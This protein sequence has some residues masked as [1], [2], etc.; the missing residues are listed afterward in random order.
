MIKKHNCILHLI[1]ILTLFSLSS[2]SYS[3]LKGLS[4]FDMESLMK[5]DLL[6]NQDADKLQKLESM[7]TGNKINPDF[8]YVGP[9]DILAYQIL[10][11]SANSQYVI[12]SPENSILLPRFGEISLKD[13]TLT[14]TKK[15]ILD[16]IS[17]RNPNTVS[18]VVLFKPRTVIA[19][20]SGNVI[21]EG[22]MT[23]PASYNISTVYKLSNKISSTTRSSLTESFAYLIFTDKKHELA[24]LNAGT[25]SPNYYQYCSRNIFVKHDDGT[26]QNADILKAYTIN[27][28]SYDQYIREGDEIIVPFE[29]DEYPRISISGA[30]LNPSTLPY[31]KGDKASFLLKIA[32]GFNEDAD[33][34]N[35]F[36]YVPGSMEKEK[37]IVDYSM[38]LQSPD[39]DLTPGSMIL[40]GSKQSEQSSDVGM[41]AISGNVKN[42]GV[43]PI[44]ND[45]TKLKDAI[46]LAG[47]F[48]EKAYL[49][50]AK[51]YRR[52]NLSYSTNTRRDFEKK[53][54]YSDLTLQDTTRFNIDQNQKLPIVSCDLNALYNGNSS[55]DNIVLKDGDLIVI[56]SNPGSVF[57]YGQINK[58][59]YIMFENEK[60]MEW[61]I[62]RAGGIAE[63]G[64]SD[65]ARII[66]GKNHTWVE[67]DDDVMVYAGDEIYIPRAEDTPPGIEMQTWAMVVS[68]LG[69]TAAVINALIWIIH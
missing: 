31:K 3:Q 9:G 36:I 25:G 16:M 15:L 41:V 51:I 50:L 28:P 54:Q 63:G 32:G 11:A 5:E 22:T 13:R 30:V 4:Q 56:P 26:S 52:S 64:K 60:N 2:N 21:S 7:P 43:Y 18:S 35:I 20:I 23:L 12:V 33:L 38:N 34:D 8:Y 39:I 69:A 10:S 29:P 6:M 66:R 42:P 24:K 59:G 45:K 48:N 37:L 47:G 44:A 57:I 1:L 67:G 46:E 65:R 62:Q 40:V 68:A 58:P 53:F 17:E 49:P 61:Y 27:D 19:T 55:I 14:G